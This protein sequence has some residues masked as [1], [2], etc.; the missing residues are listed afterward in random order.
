MSAQTTTYEID[1]S[2]DVGLGSSC[3]VF[4]TEKTINGFK[5]QTTKGTPKY[6][7]DTHNGS[8][9]NLAC[10]RNSSS[11]QLGTDYQILFPFKKDYKYQI[12]VLYKGAYAS[13]EF[14]PI[15][16]LKM[17]TAKKT[18]NTSVSCTGAQSIDIGQYQG[19]GVSG[20]SFAWSSSPLITTGAL[21]QNYESL[22]I[23][24]LTTQSPLTTQTQEIQVRTVR[25]VEIAPTPPIP[26]V[27]NDDYTGAITLTPDASTPVSGTTYQAT[28]SINVSPSCG[29]NPG[30]TFYKPDVWYKFQA[31][32][33]KHIIKADDV[34]YRG[35][36][37][38]WAPFIGLT[39]YNSGLNEMNCTFDRN[40]SLTG[41][42]VGETYYIRLW[43]AESSSTPKSIDFNVSV[44]TLGENAI[45]SVA[46]QHWAWDT[47]K[48]TASFIHDPSISVSDI[49]FDWEIVPPALGE[50]DYFGID[51]AFGSPTYE[52]YLVSQEG[53]V[54]TRVR[55][56]MRRIS[57][58][59][60]ISDWYTLP[61]LIWFG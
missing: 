53:D 27:A 57:T 5:H 21:T 7:I 12:N 34:R 47:F 30:T 4:S 59:L 31:T 43:N 32:N 39:L 28:S 26:T 56:R 18:H 46:R 13:G 24:S 15:I 42:I 58:G 49:T 25:I 22:S 33:T 2:Y 55:A 48:L 35:I 9:I 41:L 37:S 3:N 19:Q 38:S 54:A 10:K 50:A 36:V 60:P 16:G 1:Y 29:A 61:N 23:A 8:H 17:N 6:T 52:S 45:T 44:S 20:P 40:I 51:I 14:V 11:S